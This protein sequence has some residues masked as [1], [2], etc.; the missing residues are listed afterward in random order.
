[1]PPPKSKIENPKSHWWQ[2]LL[3][4]AARPSAPDAE[5]VFPPG[6]LESLERLRVAA[7]KAAG[8]GL[9]EGHR[10]GAFRGGQL[11]F[12]DHRSYSP[13]DDLRYLDWSLYARL[14]RPFV[15]EFAR[16]EAGCLHLLLDA[17]PSMQLG[18]PSKWTFARRLAA[19]FGHVAWKAHDLVHACAF[20]GPGRE[21]TRYPARGARPS[22]TAFVD[23][24]RRERLAEPEPQAADAPARAEAGALNEA[25][26]AFLRA[27]PPRGHVF[28]I[29]DFWQEE[30]ELAESIRLLGA[31]G[32]DVAGIH[33]LAA[34]E[35]LPPETGPVR[36]LN[37]EAAGELELTLTPAALARYAAELDAHAQAV[38]RIFRR[39]GGL[40]LHERSDTPLEKILIQTLRRRRW[41]A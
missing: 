6:F 19:L 21:L 18:R 33:V 25:V 38:Q 11:E 22:S 35:L 20:R 1:M 39:R 23:W 7:L 29:G 30:A 9:H 16:E 8:G 36:V 28:V 5:V 24:L 37:L 32:H 26:R 27:G 31:A 3:P 40:Y 15:K 34:E 17:T 12:H 4:F 14:G 41:V 10:L 2:R 13:G